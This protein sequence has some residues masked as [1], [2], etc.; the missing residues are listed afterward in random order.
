MHACRRGVRV[1][2]P[3]DSTDPSGTPRAENAGATERRNSHVHIAEVA[4]IAVPSAA[5]LADE[6]RQ[7]IG[8]VTDR[9]GFVPNVARL[10]PIPPSRFVGW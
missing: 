6:I 8:P 2:A 3:L 4:W 10:L 1:P 9:I 7:A 5:E